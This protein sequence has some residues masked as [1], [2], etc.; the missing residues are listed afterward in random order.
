MHDF[1]VIGFGFCVSDLC[2]EFSQKVKV[3]LKV[4]GQYCL[5]DEEAKTLKFHVI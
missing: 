2:I 4:C 3:L 5:N 1:Q